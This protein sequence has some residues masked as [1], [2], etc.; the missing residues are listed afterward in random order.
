M[1]GQTGKITMRTTVVELE[2][3]I[4]T[5]H[6]EYDSSADMGISSPCLSTRAVIATYKKGSGV[7]T[8]RCAACMAPFM[9]LVIA[10]NHEK[11]VDIAANT[12]LLLPAKKPRVKRVI[13]SV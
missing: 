8:L 4:A 11:P 13:K 3:D 2:R 9:D 5:L 10:P 6:A 12:P 7:V 1:V